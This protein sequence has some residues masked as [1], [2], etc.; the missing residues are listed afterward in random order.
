MAAKPFSGYPCPVQSCRTRAILLRLRRWH[1]T[2]FILTW[3]TRDFGKLKTLAKGARRPKSLMRGALDLFFCD[4]ILFLRSGKS[5][6][7]LLQEAAVVES[8]PRIR[9]NLRAFHAASYFTVLCDQMTAPEHPAPELY[10]LLEEF[11]AALNGGEA[12]AA[13]VRAFEFRL[14]RALGLGARVE[15]LG[16]PRGSAAL[17]RHLIEQPLAQLERLKISV[18]Q[19]QELDERAAGLFGPYLRQWPEARALALGESPGAQA[20]LRK[21]PQA[22]PS[23][24]SRI[25]I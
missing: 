14:L 15:Q 9:G 16:L 12:S 22:F 17:L 11:L 13:L 21:N 4:E 23:L 20:T 19:A 2:S 10:G 5:E 1:E 3:L 25:G 7:H 18:A 6:L 8:F 24:P